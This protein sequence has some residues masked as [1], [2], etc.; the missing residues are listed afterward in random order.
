[1]SGY[2]MLVRWLP[3]IVGEASRVV[4]VAPVYDGMDIGPT[5]K[6]YCGELLDLDKVEQLEGPA[7]M[8]CTPCVLNTPL[9]GGPAALP[10]R[11]ETQ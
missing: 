7:G 2:V 5:L 8:P 1:M 9:D 11:E 10:A 4:H 6:A 3:G